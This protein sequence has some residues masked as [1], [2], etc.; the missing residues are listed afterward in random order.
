M[1][2]LFFIFSLFVFHSNAYTITKTIEYF[3]QIEF[4]T[5]MSKISGQNDEID[6]IGLYHKDHKT[7]IDYSALSQLTQLKSLELEQHGGS[8]VSVEN[9]MSVLETINLPLLEEIKLD[10]GINNSKLQVVLDWLLQFENL[11][12]IDFS[13]NQFYYNLEEIN[14]DFAT[15][16]Q[17]KNFK[18]LYLSHTSNVGNHTYLTRIKGIENLNN[19]EEIDYSLNNSIDTEEIQR[20]LSIPTLQNLNFSQSE[21]PNNFQDLFITILPNLKMLNLEATSANLNFANFTPYLE[22]LKV[23]H[24]DWT[25]HDLRL[26]GKFTQLEHLDISYD[27]TLLGKYSHPRSFLSKDNLWELQAMDPLLNLK[28]LNLN[29][30]K[31]RGIDFV[32]APNLEKLI[33][34]HSDAGNGELT[35][36]AK[37]HHLEVLDLSST[38]V[39]NKGL[40]H[41]S[42][43]RELKTLFLKYLNMN[44][45]NFAT[46]QS[47]ENL[48]LEYAELNL[49]SFL[50]LFE[51]HNLKTLN[52]KGI[53]SKHIDANAIEQLKLALPNCVI[54]TK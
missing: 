31:I 42:K 11:K 22:W 18:G 1:K 27:A 23:S 36:V 52:I 3:D 8:I 19:L 30:Q 10:L 13:N 29:K 21:L 39:S 35:K 40:R 15:L 4:D 38:K 14:Y 26:L 20:I 33:L 25:N 34:A 24:Y 37:L 54:T 43:L 9:M 47:L 49:D 7:M 50:T 53:K 32:F 12:K 5:Q 28:S 17:L 51:L 48:D 6:K 45:A 16:N 46:L 44:K 2:F 41:L